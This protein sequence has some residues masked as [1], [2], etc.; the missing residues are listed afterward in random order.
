MLTEEGYIST[1]NI[2]VAPVLTE[3]RKKLKIASLISLI[4]GIAG[5]IAYV[6]LSV[7]LM[8]AGGDSPRWVD[9]FLIFA[10]P[11][12]FG[13]VLYISFVRLHSREKAEG[14]KAKCLF[15]AD[16]FVYNCKSLQKITE[17]V[18]KTAYADAVLKRENEKYG[19]IFSKKGLFFVFSK[20]G[21]KAEELN[22]IRKNFSKPF[23]G[24]TS[25][26]KNY[27]PNEE[28]K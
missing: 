22:A 20:E 24:E 13:L 26:L 27:K 8:D 12:A 25:E 10:V 21:L 6:V 5:V 4:V 7:V 19:Y 2:A 28:N 3:Y 1:E 9:I 17:T 16:C 18:E 23:D 15:C 11:C 14:A